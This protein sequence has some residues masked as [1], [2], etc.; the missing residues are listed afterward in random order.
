[1]KETFGG[2]T[3]ACAL[4]TSMGAFAHDQVEYRWSLRLKA[5]ILGGD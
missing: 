5:G 3:L 1:M 4:I 2:L